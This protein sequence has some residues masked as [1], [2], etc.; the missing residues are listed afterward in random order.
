MPNELMMVARKAKGSKIRELFNKARKSAEPALDHLYRHR[1]MYAG[2]TAGGALGGG[3]GVGAGAVVDSARD[4]Q[5]DNSSPRTGKI[6]GGILG[7]AGGAAGGARLGR[8]YRNVAH[9][10]RRAG[11]ST[12]DLPIDVASHVGERIGREG[13]KD[14]RA[15]LGSR[16]GAAKA[17]GLDPKQMRTQA[18]AD[19][20]LRAQVMQAHPDKGGNHTAF[21]AATDIQDAVKRQAWYSRLPAGS[22]KKASL[23]EAIS[24]TVRQADFARIEE[25]YSSEKI[26]TG[27]A[28]CPEIVASL[29]TIVGNGIVTDEDRV[30]VADSLTSGRFDVVQVRP[31]RYGYLV[32]WAAAPDGVQPQQQEMTAPQAQ[33]VLP[34][35][36]LQTADQEGSATVTQVQAEPD[37]LEENPEPIQGFGLYKVYEAGTGAQLTGFV[38]PGLYDPRTA[39][40]TSM[41]LF[42]TGGQYALQQSMVGTLITV[43]HNLPEDRNE[44]RGLGVFYKSN[45]RNLLATIPFTVISKMTV[46]NRTYYAAQ[47]PEGSEVQITPSPGINKPIAVSPQE[48]AIPEDYSWLPLNNEV[49][50]EDG[51]ADVMAPA[52]TA[53]APT[54]AVIRAWDGGCSL[55][56]PVFEKVGSGDHSTEDGLFWLAAAGMPHKLA[57]ACIEKAASESRSIKMYGLQPL[58]RGDNRMKEAVASAAATL[59]GVSIPE[60]ECLL[61]EA[62]VIGMSKEA[63]AVVGVNTLD[64]ILSLN[65]INPE[66]IESFIDYIPDLE[67][68]MSKLANLV[69]ASQL[70]LQSVQKTAAVRAMRSMDKVVTFLKNMKETKI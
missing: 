6:V 25:L 31:T 2:G 61:H 19:R 57:K 26:A 10:I 50:L 40:P 21:L 41:V 1:E 23:S 59:R 52:K 39:Q 70:G 38:I 15:G 36:M 13:A 67:D 62:L 53:A 35:E 37:P 29:K 66:N 65:F 64:H 58:S 28:A 24:G 46:E 9:I 60:K 63:K 4:Q 45:G 47:T 42:T 22:T 12:K 51:G 68:S 20:Y 7:A 33:Q 32:K 5:P 48:I 56:G 18:D 16:R 8:T 34:Q 69:L 30:K 3:L 43:A 27:L 49:Q 44:P 17:L 54:L 14:L 11:E 55:S